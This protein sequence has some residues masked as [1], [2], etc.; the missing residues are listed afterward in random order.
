MLGVRGIAGASVATAIGVVTVG[1]GA[2]AIEEAFPAPKFSLQSDRFDLSTIK[3]RFAKQLTNCDPTTLLAQEPEV[4]AAQQLLQDFKEKKVISATDAD[5]WRARKLVEAAIHPDTKEI[6]PRPFRMSGYVPYN[7]PVC[8]AMMASSSTPALLFW[9]WINQS[10]N[11]L[12]NYFNRNASSPTSNETLAVSYCAAVGAALSV[13]FGLS[14]FI[15]RRYSPERAKQL[16]KFVAFPSSMVA[17]CS[18]CY[19]MRSPEIETG[20]YITDADGNVLADGQRSSNAARKAVQETVMSR[21]VLQIPVFFIPPMLMSLPPFSLI[22]SGAAVVS[23]TTLFT[24]VSFGFGLPATVAIF[25]QIGT[26]KVEELEPELQAA[27]PAQANGMV[28]YNKG[29]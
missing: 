9:N 20:V 4:R 18:N 27:I 26:L 7:G 14:T 2:Q 5:L 22:G 28:Y 23:I 12:V 21:A 3:G 29:L 10:H 1:F 16:L 24:I 11:A 6:I 17:S 15:S 25:P 19:I 8:V 13:A